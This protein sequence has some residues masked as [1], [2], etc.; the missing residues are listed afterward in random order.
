MLPANGVVDGV[1]LWE[2]EADHRHAAPLAAVRLDGNARM[3]LPFT[4]DLCPTHV[5][6][7]DYPSLTGYVHC[8]G[9][10]C[11]LCRVGR[12]KDVCYLWP[13]YDVL[14][15]AVAV[16]PISHNRRP[17]ALQPLLSPVLKRVKEGKDRFFIEVRKPNL[18]TFT[19]ATFPLPA[20][21]DDG[22]AAVKAFLEKLKAGHVDL[23]SVYRRITNEDLAMYP[24][25]AT[26]M[27]MKGIGLS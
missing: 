16:V 14:A 8:N 21:A 1:E 11:L 12:R 18:Y 3:L 20:D 15:G 23:G 27:Q 10:D 7:L 26:A 13:V 17:N 6:Y 9:L 25:V 2:S 24:E 4:A 5:H 22:A 19:V